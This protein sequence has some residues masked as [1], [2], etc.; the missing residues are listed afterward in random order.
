MYMDKKNLLLKFKE[1][2]IITHTNKP[3][4]YNKLIC[5]EDY[6]IINLMSAKACEIINFFQCSDNLCEVKNIVNYFLRHSLAATLARKY[7]TSVKKIFLKYGKNFVIRVNNHKRSIEIAKY[8][9]K[10]EVYTLKAKFNE[11]SINYNDLE[12]HLSSIHVDMSF[13]TRFKNF[14]ECGIVEC[15]DIENIKVY[16]IRKIVIRYK[17][18]LIHVQKK[19]KLDLS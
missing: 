13:I 10:F 2:G 19:E 16:Q 5:L 17:V 7:K 14:D 15:N 6:Y 11:N 9:S 3:T 8:P 12:K 4:S 18:N 1:L